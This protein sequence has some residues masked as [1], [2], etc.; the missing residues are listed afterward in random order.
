MS[1]TVRDWVEAA[2]SRVG[3]AA[4]RRAADADQSGQFPLDDLEELRASGLMGLMVPTDLHGTDRV[5]V[6]EFSRVAYLLGAGSIPVAL[7]W[8]MHSQQA[9]MLVEHLPEKLRRQ[10]L[11]EISAGREYVASVTTESLTGSSIRRSKSAGTLSSNLYTLDRYAPIVTGGRHADSFLVKIQDPSACS[12]HATVFVYVR[13]EEVEVEVESPWPMLGM[14]AVEN[15]GLRIHGEVH[16]E[17]ILKSTAS[18]Q[19]HTWFAAL[20][21][22]GWASAWIGCTEAAMSGALKAVHAQRRQLLASTSF[23]SGLGRL[24]ERLEAATALLETC[25]RRADSGTSDLTGVSDQR[26]LNAL[27]TFAAREC[28]E[29]VDGLIDIVGLAEGYRT[30]AESGLERAFRDLRAARLMYS[31]DKLYRANGALTM[32]RRSNP[33]IEER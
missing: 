30:D 9:S 26:A 18:P 21:H 5:A 25:V 15:V 29:I 31:D 19:A 32:F 10:V 4:A 20:A 23:T 14:R 33:L 28:F 11:H 1:G 6:A 3:L 8:A 24:W 16:S 2:A 17:R 12:E 7:I 22:I 13:K 27:K